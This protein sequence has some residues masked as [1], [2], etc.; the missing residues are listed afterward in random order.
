MYCGTK[1]AD[2]EAWIRGSMHKDM[3]NVLPQRWAE[4]MTLSTTGPVFA[5]I[6]PI[7]NMKSIVVDNPYL[8]SKQALLYILISGSLE[9]V[10]TP[11]ARCSS[12]SFDS[13]FFL[14]SHVERMFSLQ[15]M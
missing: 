10:S 12:K 6:D 5:I 15:K 1:I 14:V 3:V 4:Y 8:T 2:F 7:L 13:K 11:S 9:E